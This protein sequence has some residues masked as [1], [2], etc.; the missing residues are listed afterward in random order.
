MELKLNPVLGV[1]F[2]SN[3]RK[4]KLAAAINAIEKAVNSKEFI[5]FF[6]TAKFTQLGSMQKLTRE[7]ML[8]RIYIS[9]MF[10]YSVI[11]RSWW[12]R[13]SSVI[14]YSQD[15][16]K[17]KGPDVYTYADSY[18]GMSVVGLAGH[19]LHELFHCMGFEHSFKW[20]KE[21]DMSIPYACGNFVETLIMKD[22]MK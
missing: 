7:Q 10:N 3:E 9:L 19:A 2:K 18:D 6:M 13:F 4:Q 1:G 5:D 17:T 22:Q 20:N 11:E 8:L 16:F 21:R 14:G 15:N 12:K